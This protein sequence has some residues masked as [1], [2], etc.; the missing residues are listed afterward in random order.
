MDEREIP[1]QNSKGIQGYY[2]IDGKVD[3]SLPNIYWIC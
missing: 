1:S 3:I 2:K